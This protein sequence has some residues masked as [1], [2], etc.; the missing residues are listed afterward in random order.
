MNLMT[1]MLLLIVALLIPVIIVFMYANERSIA[2]VEEQINAANQNRLDNFMNELESTLDQF[3][4]YANIITKDPDFAELAGNGPA[5]SRY[6]YARQLASLE[7]K[8]ALFTL[9]SDQL[10]RITMYFPKTGQAA[11]S[12]SSAEYDETRIGRQLSNR[13]TLRETGEG[14]VYKRAFTRY[15][16]EPYSQVA[17][18][19]EASIIV[20]V[21]LYADNIVRLLDAF[22][23]KGIN[24]PFLMK[25]P[26]SLLLNTTAEKD[27][28]EALIASYRPDPDKPANVLI[29]DKVYLVYA[30]TSE[31]LGWTL[32]DYVPLQDILAPV[33]RSKRLFYVMIGILLLFGIA[34][35][36]LL[37]SQV[38]LP[39]RLLTDSVLKL[40]SGRYSTRIPRK[41]N[42]EFQQLIEQFNEM[43]AETEHLIEKVYKEEIR[44]K[45]A[46][47]KQLQSQIN[48]HFLYN[49]L[50]FVASMAKLSRT[51]PIITF[52]HRLADYF[53]YTTRNEQMTT[54]LQEEI[55]FVLSYLD[56][57]NHQLEQL[58]CEVSI[59][60][61]MR[62]LPVPR[63]FIQPI[64]E[65][66]V[67]HGIEPKGEAGLIRIA[68]CETEAQVELTVE[69]DGLGMEAADLSSLQERLESEDPD[70]ESRGLRNV[71]QRLR[72]HYGEAAELR[73]DHGSLGRGIRVRLR[74]SRR[75]AAREGGGTDVHGTHRRRP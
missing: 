33:N 64:V 69:D 74:W 29:D 5:M 63:L 8:L 40:K 67:L 45:E 7:R 56:I 14:G 68:A 51:A 44:T 54:T 3:A 65:N 21:E 61:S 22:K 17:S 42:R 36:Y 1:K 50:A 49:S 16:V 57:M 25:A 62:S 66:A 59:P 15:F 4:K 75:S 38:Q 27:R 48:P 2:V 58:R 32:V 11:S 28:V 52:A 46:V 71:L 37:Y 9:S 72:L 70:G 39:I 12:T 73:V 34:A 41:Q 47:M 31:E 43:A 20:E 30:L 10:S 35:A 6:E 53:R 19:Q 24:D 55:D 23:S 13:W 26:E 60:E 18:L